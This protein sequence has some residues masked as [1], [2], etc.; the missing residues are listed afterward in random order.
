MSTEEALAKAM[1]IVRE[2]SEFDGLWVCDDGWTTNEPDVHSDD[3][4]WTDLRAAAKELVAEV[5]G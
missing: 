5:D 4:E 2:I 1:A 3:R